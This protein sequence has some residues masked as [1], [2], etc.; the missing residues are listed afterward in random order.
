MKKQLLA[1][2]LISLGYVASSYGMG[3]AIMAEWGKLKKDVV[4][5][6]S[7]TVYA[8]AIWI[9]DEKPTVAGQPVLE[10]EETKPDV[11]L[12]KH[13]N[14][15]TA[16]LYIKKQKS[17]YSKNHA[18][19]SHHHCKPAMI[20]VRPAKKKKTKD[21][22]QMMDDNDKENRNNNNRKSSKKRSHEEMEDMMEHNTMMPE[23]SDEK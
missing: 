14:P 9:E 2:T 6:T 8:R 16:T 22:N 15:G 18:T 13:L 20:T 4:E 12:V 23:E 10:L 21:N 3:V 17:G 7:Q 11:W 1:L 5:N 19:Q